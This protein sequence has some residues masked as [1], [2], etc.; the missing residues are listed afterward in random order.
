[1]VGDSLG[2]GILNHICHLA[3]LNHI[4]NQLLDKGCA[5]LNKFD[6]LL[7]AIRLHTYLAHLPHLVEQ[8]VFVA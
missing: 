8:D 6:K 4:G 2:A 7:V 3:S 1:M 5:M